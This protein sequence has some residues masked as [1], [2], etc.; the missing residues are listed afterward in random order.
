MTEGVDSSDLFEGVVRLADS[1]LILGQQLSGWTANGPTVELDIALQNQSL[2]LIGQARFLYEHAGKVEGRGRGEDDLAY[3]RDAHEYRN[4]LLVEQP[5]GDFAQTMLRQFLYAAFAELL[6]DAMQGSR[7]EEL[8]AIASKAGKEMAYHLRHAGEWVVRLGDGTAE[9]HERL[10]R[11]LANLWP[12]VHDMFD[13]DEVDARLQA[14]GIMPD[15]AALKPEWLEIVGSVFE[16][17]GLEIPGDDWMP[18]GGRAGQHG[19]RLSYILAE[20]QVV[21]R[22]DP[23]AVW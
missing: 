14:A 19:E 2:D 20:M 13:A 10:E 4:F 15:I 7:D 23:E 11:G 6:F 5:N 18:T 16:R 17:A 22:S 3:F 21:A 8:A 9:S 1:A 12:Y